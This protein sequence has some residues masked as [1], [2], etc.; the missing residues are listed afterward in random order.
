MTAGRKVVE[1]RPDIDWDK[2]S[3]LKW[4]Q[5]R[6][7]REGRSIAIYIGDDLTDE[8]AFDAL[9]A[10]GVGIAVRHDEDLDRPTAARFTLA[11]PGQVREF[12][13]R[14][15]GWL[16]RQHAASQ[17]AWTYTFEGYDPQSE[18]LREALCT[19]GNGYF[20]TRGAGPESK[21]GQVHY[22]G[23]YAAGVYNRLDDVISGRRVEHESLVNLPNWL[24][25]TFRVDGGT[26][27]DVDA[28]TLLSYRQTLDLHG[29]CL[30]VRY[31]SATRPAA[32][33]R[34]PRTGWCR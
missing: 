28:V 8:D 2:G 33:P 34:L 4:I 23:T 12:L 6:L 32:S 27:F 18:K 19:V 7:P 11:D 3:A 9:R 25:L 17:V 14:G 10:G 5:N 1:L 26:W 21:P 30:L 22:P 13:H 29:G 15:A 16:A 20:A 31:V 24:P